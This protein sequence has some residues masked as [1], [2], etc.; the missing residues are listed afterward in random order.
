MNKIHVECDETGDCIE[1]RWS[2]NSLQYS[3]TQ[4]E[5]VKAL[6]DSQGN[7]L[8]FKISGISLMGEGEKDFINIQLLPLN[9]GP[10]LVS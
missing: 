1:V 2:T 7:V 9:P 6:I 3:D 10:D 8:G 5:R 4:D